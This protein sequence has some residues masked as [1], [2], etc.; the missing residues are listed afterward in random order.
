MI[1]AENIQEVFRHYEN[2]CYYNGMQV[3]NC[4]SHHPWKEDYE[5]SMHRMGDKF[6]KIG[7]DI[8]TTKNLRGTKKK[9]KKKEVKENLNDPN[10]E[11]KSNSSIK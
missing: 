8:K 1:G 5:K 11:K 6:S 3:P 7:K 4:V 9:S 2:E 10:D